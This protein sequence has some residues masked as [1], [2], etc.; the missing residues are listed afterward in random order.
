MRSAR[1]QETLEQ[2]HRPRKAN[3]GTMRSARVHEDLDLFRSRREVNDDGT[4]VRR[5]I[6]PAA[7]S[8]AFA[9]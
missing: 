8:G 7:Y 6:L 5:K 1:A 3:A 9:T 4:I 2:A